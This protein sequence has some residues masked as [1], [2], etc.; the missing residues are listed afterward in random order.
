[1]ETVSKARS[2]SSPFARLLTS[3]TLVAGARVAGAVL[4]ISLQ[5]ALARSF[6]AESLGVFFLVMAVASVLSVVCTLGYPMLVAKVVAESSERGNVAW[7]TEFLRSA[8][9]DVLIASSLAA[10]LAG[11]IVLFVPSFSTNLRIGLMIGVLTVPVAALFRLNSALAN[12][13][14]YFL[15]GF[16]P[17]LIGRPFLLLLA[18]IAMVQLIAGTTIIAVIAVNFALVCCVSAWQYSRL[19]AMQSTVDGATDPPPPRSI[20]SLATGKAQTALWRRD[21]LQLSIAAVFMA[22]FADL[23]VLMASV[24]LEKTDLGIFGTCL[25][26]S[27]FVA[28]AIQAIHQICFRDLADALQQE[29]RTA[30]RTSIARGN[31]IAL[32]TSIVALVAISLFATPILNL[33]GPEFVEGRICLIVLM[34]AQILRASAGP[35]TQILALTGHGQSTIPIYLISVLLLGALGMA[36]IPTHGI[37]GAAVAVVSAT[38]FWSYGLMLLANRREGLNTAVLR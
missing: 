6:G 5:I 7:L 10:L 26:V 36:L 11:I 3:S 28:F 32:T 35:A 17:E 18:T 23:S 38:A 14:R 1:M 13:H 25:R 20:G 33:L 8:R 21:A 30:L 16:F 9:R 34:L 31:V 19:G 22:V 27:F 12:A 37:N 4:G 29:N 15:T 24:F 2:V